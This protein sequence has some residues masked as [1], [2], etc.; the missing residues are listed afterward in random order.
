MD[1][2]LS[3]LRLM[4]REKEIPFEELVQIIEQ[5]ILTAY[6]K[7]THQGEPLKQA[8]EEEPGARVVL[9]RKSGHVDIYIPEHDEEGNI[10]GE[11]VDNPDDFGRIAAFAAKQVINQRLRDI[12]DDAVLG[13]F[14]GREGEIV[15]GVIQQGPNPRMIHVD[16]GT[17]EA[18]LPPE[19]QVPGE[20][21]VH[22][23]RIRV[24]VTAVGR[25]M[26][27]PQITVSRTHPSLVRRLFALEVPEIASGV[28]EIVS[29]AREAG[30]R[31]KIAVRATEPGVNAKG[32]CIGEL[33]QRVRAVTSELNN[34]KIDI[35]DY[36]PDLAT[37]VASAL[38]PAKVTSAYV[39]DE[40]IKAVRALVPD[41]QLSLAIGKEGQ[42][43]RLAAKL[44]G[45]KIDIQ[46]DSI[47]ED[48]E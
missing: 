32:A 4:E 11:A 16:L 48:D 19:E 29:L 25:G 39:I 6:L 7:H 38:S 13:E 9:D 36:S 2:D 35:V 28:V 31:T 5:A 26:K 45:A 20:S 3:V 43:A 44:T 1:I 41:Y 30:H 46:P 22:G 15:A 23:S 14:K 33:G 47:L 42:N 17:I 8:A 40:S 27:G 37:F 18:I 21:Y 34:E 12:A 10:I 24:Y